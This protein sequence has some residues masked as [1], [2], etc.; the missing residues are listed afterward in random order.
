MQERIVKACIKHPKTWGLH[1]G[2]RHGDI[3]QR[4]YGT[5]ALDGLPGESMFGFLTSEGRFVDRIEAAIIAHDAG[6]IEKPQRCLQSQ[7]LW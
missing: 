2:R 5:G 4:M 7:D 1:P 6:Q 3:L